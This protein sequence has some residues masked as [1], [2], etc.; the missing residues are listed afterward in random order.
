MRRTIMHAHALQL[1]APVSDDFPA[2]EGEVR[3]LLNAAVAILSQ[4]RTILSDI[5]MVKLDR[6]VGII[7][8]RGSLLTVQ[9]NEIMGALTKV[10]ESPKQLVDLV[11]ELQKDL[12]SWMT[13]Q[14]KWN[15]SISTE[16]NNIQRSL[17]HEVTSTNA[18]ADVTECLDKI[19]D[20][21]ADL[22]AVADLK[23]D[24]GLGRLMRELSDL[25]WEV[26]ALSFCAVI[27]FA[28]LIGTLRHW[29]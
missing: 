15:E 20:A 9:L 12:W 1:G 19:G 3:D 17:E 7:D 4:M 28:L 27:G 18:I 6:L 5:E 24:V 29:F 25:N 16:L 26:K 8:D 10:G 11:S 2:Y 14:Q 13:I 21:L 22:K 23:A